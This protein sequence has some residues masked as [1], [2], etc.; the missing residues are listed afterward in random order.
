MF[1]KPV[2]KPGAWLRSIAFKFGE[3]E[4]R[5][6]YAANAPRSKVRAAEV[7]W[8]VLLFKTYFKFAKLVLP[9]FGMLVK[10]VWFKKQEFPYHYVNVDNLIV[11]G[12][13]TL[14]PRL[15]RTLLLIRNILSHKTDSFV[16]SKS[17]ISRLVQFLKAWFSKKL[18]EIL[19]SR[20][21]KLL[22]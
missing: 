2:V 20:V 22:L 10:L 8:V 3:F 13:G 1:I 5:F 9:R 7:Y 11:C 4:N 14:L 21:L 12:F 17:T 19:P 16:F 6:I 15:F 18:F